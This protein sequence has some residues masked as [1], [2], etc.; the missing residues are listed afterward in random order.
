MPRIAQLAESDPQDELLSPQILLFKK[1]HEMF[2]KKKT[3]SVLIIIL[4][5]ACHGQLCQ[6][7]TAPSQFVRL[8]TSAHH[9]H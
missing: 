2:G 4:S 7:S 8:Q 5:D 3:V 9:T 1:C 6:H